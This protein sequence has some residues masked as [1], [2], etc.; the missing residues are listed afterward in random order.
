MRLVGTS[1]SKTYIRP[2]LDLLRIYTRPLRCATPHEH[3]VGVVVMLQVGYMLFSRLSCDAAFI[4]HLSPCLRPLGRVPLSFVVF[5]ARRRKRAIT[6]KHFSL[7]L[8][9]LA[10]M[11]KY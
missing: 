2:D 5:T 8:Y 7:K 6:L 3:K 9:T 10:Y 11:I 4:Y 1:G